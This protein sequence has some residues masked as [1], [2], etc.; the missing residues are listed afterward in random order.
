MTLQQFLLILRARA[1]VALLTLLVTIA[2]AT[3][4]SLVMQ[5]QYTASTAIVIDVKS[6][7]PIAG[8]VLPG[9]ISPGYM[10]TQ[11]DIITSD[12]VAQR[13]VN[14]LKMDKND[15][16][17]E[18]WLEATEGK[19]DIVAWIASALQKKLDVKPSRESNVINIAFTGSDPTFAAAAADAFAHAYID[20]NLELKVEPARQNAVWFESQTKSLCATSLKPRKQRCPPTSESRAS[21]RRKSGWITKRQ[22]STNSR[23][24]SRSF[25]P[26]PPTVQ[27]RTSLPAVRTLSRRCSRTR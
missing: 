6:P 23:H 12:R 26:K 27:A 21:S 24:S 13:V 17:R 3:A 15:T 11:V 22:N 10:A 14:I 16:I 25:R 2:A 19:G 8:L 5:K 18:K 20:I 7:D 9:L 4:I 1:G